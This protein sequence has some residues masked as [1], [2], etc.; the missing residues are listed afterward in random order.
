VTKNLSRGTVRKRVSPRFFFRRLDR[1]RALFGLAR[2]AASYN[3]S[4][5][6]DSKIV[7][8]TGGH[9]KGIFA[10]FQRLLGTSLHES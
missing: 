4:L 7:Y 1:R 9:Y 8:F 5:F 3:Q 6:I 2:L 10:R